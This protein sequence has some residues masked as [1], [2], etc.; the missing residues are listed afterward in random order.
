MALLT[1]ASWAGCIT[2]GAGGQTNDAALDAAIDIPEQLDGQTVLAGDDAAS[3]VDTLMHGIPLQSVG[4]QA[5]PVFAHR[6]GHLA[7]L[8][9]LVIASRHELV[10]GLVA[11]RRRQP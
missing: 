11:G 9:D 2:V 1:V 7:L 6:S 5:R 3:D 4:S 8:V 10:H